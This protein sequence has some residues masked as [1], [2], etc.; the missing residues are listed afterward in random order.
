MFSKGDPVRHQSTE[1]YIGECKAMGSKPV[2]IIFWEDSTG[3]RVNGAVSKTTS[4][5]K[6][7]DTISKLSINQ[8]DRDIHN[9][10]RGLR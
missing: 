7:T 4:R 10:A 9:Q 3:Q 5:N 8:I 6:V 1:V 2:G